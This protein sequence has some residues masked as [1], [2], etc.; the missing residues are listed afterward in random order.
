[1]TQP[2]LPQC[3]DDE[4]LAAWVDGRLSKAETAVLIEHASTC[5]ECLPMID[6]ANET[7]HAEAVA[8]PVRMWT[9]RRRW[10][11]A[12]AAVLMIALPASFLLVRSN[13]HDPVQELVDGAPRSV[14]AS[15]ARFSG[16]FAWA[17]YRGSMRAS[18]TAV[19]R[20][21]MK[22]VG[23]AAE[24]LDRAEHD[25]SAGA[26]RAA[27][28]AMV[29]IDQAE[30]GMARLA[31]ETKRSPR[32]AGAWSDLAA[33]QYAG[34]LAG[35]TSLY[36]EALASADRAL[37][38]DPSLREG[39][40]NRALVLERLGL[41]NQARAAWQSYLDH[42]SSSPW[43]AEA[44]EHLGRLAATGAAVPFD[45]DR[46]RLETAAAAGD[47]RMVG[48]LA[49]RHGERARAYA[50]V[51]YLG[52]WAEGLQK[53][54][55]A[56]ATRWLTISRNIG[57]ALAGISG[58]SLLRDAVRTIDAADATRQQRIAEAHVVYRRGR[59]AFSRRDLSGGERD[60]RLAAA[61][62]SAAGDP[63]S[64]AARS[65]AAGARLAQNDVVAARGELTA[66]A[67]EV[68]AVRGYLSLAGQVRWEL[69]RC[70]IFDGDWNT[71][72]RVLAE[73]ETLFRRAGEPI[74]EA[75]IAMMLADAWTA[76][77]RPDDA[78]SARTR[79]FATFAGAGTIEQLQI[80]VDGAAADALR[81]G[82]PETAR[83]LIGVG[84]S[85]A[86]DAAND[87]LLAD[88]L[89]R[90]SLLDAASDPKAAESAAAGATTAALRI[91]D[92]AL[93]ARY[94][95][96]A[97]LAM[98][99][100]LVD[101]DAQRSSDLS[102][103]AL[104]TYTANGLTGL[105]AEPYLVRARASLRLGDR[106]AAA[107]DLGA[108]IDAVEQHPA[109]A[110]G[111][112]IG[113]GVLDAG[114]ALFEEAIALDLDRNDVRS[115]FAHAERSRGVA[116]GT[117]ALDELR[118]RLAGSGTAVVVSIVLPRELVLLAV[119][120]GS[121]S[122]SR[123]KMAREDVVA[124]AA[125]SDDSALHDL[126]IR[127][128]ATALA[129]A[130]SVIIVPDKLLERVVYA[131]LRDPATNRRLLERMSVATAGSATSLRTSPAPARRVTM[132]AIELPSGTT[133]R[134][135]AL[136]EAELELAEI[137]GLYGTVRQ[138]S[139]DE[140]TAQAVEEYGAAADVVH[141]AGHTEENAATGGEALAAGSSAISW[142]TI[143][144]MRGMA[145]V[146]VLSAC[147]TLRRPDDPNR[148]ALS[149]GGAFVAA[150]AQDVFGT[151]E[152]IGDRDARGLFFALHEQLARGVAAPEALRRVQLA[153]I[154]RPDG[155]WRRLALLTTIIHR[156]TD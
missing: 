129:S 13:R 16:G 5:E 120:E 18:G 156:N 126:L 88:M 116:A 24:A 155:A 141:I 38:I 153:Q 121:V 6:A 27:G 44:R 10:L 39:L 12:A 37:R 94:L 31:A 30:E 11:L 32:D 48:T 146:V 148:R 137:G 98:A 82:N 84:E 106:A 51:E 97:D 59:I 68:D 36:P 34:A 108:G 110:G 1:M 25:P 40:F 119:T 107:R 21:Q 142:R 49:G 26:Q 152:P 85:L 131:A 130:H 122:A 124:M 71:A 83:A 65:Y 55:I 128:A 95:A 17:P 8:A 147:N 45:T 58:E 109:S 90:K 101:S 50:E 96:D 7:F 61:Q 104:E 86:R 62:F 28:V 70:L 102:S 143:A 123:R 4:T 72:A 9:G 150:G 76:A 35:R 79:A 125:H 20:E 91:P 56:E 140:V 118:G 113:T 60:L 112:V 136:P 43:A 73:A 105:V 103:R 69:A 53:K 89:T 99:A 64:L 29:L 93:R 139:P 111:T 154:G 77:G 114:S 132:T 33:A 63:M 19:D 54:D 92:P 78:W 135:A 23:A 15:E 134:S 75:T 3:P 22:L 81:A 100:A 149:L 57:A 74:N 2:P 117:G 52:R 133:V 145:P 47:E 138:V 41:R 127:P 144:A 87:L 66:L 80:A 14:R 115:A 67:A 151:L 42:D 46:Q